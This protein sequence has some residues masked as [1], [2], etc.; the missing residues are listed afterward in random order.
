MLIDWCVRKHLPSEKSR[1]RDLCIWPSQFTDKSLETQRLLAARD[2]M[3][4]QQQNKG[5]LLN[6]LVLSNASLPR[7]LLSSW[8]QGKNS[9]MGN[10][11]VGMYVSECS[12]FIFQGLCHLCQV[13][14]DIMFVRDQLHIFPKLKAFLIMYASSYFPCFRDHEYIKYRAFYWLC[15]FLGLFFPSIRWGS[16][17]N[18]VTGV[19]FK[20]KIV[21]SQWLWW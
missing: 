21:W 17:T 16:W 7:Y 19:S 3:A 4:H 8:Q 6:L 15:L 5:Q 10:M 18:V 12:W 13:S 2:H 14:K 20:W 1:G 11:C 9:F